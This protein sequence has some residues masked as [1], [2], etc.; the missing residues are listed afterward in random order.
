M[1]F[2]ESEDGHED[3]KRPD[4]GPEIEA[5]YHAYS[6]SLLTRAVSMVGDWN[7]AETLVHDVFVRVV[8]YFNNGRGPVRHTHGWLTRILD[9]LIVDH[10]RH[11]AVFRLESDEVLNDV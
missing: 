4:V 1:V 5:M 7:Q 2:D 3:Q 6:K 10:Y 11:K 8:V 9:C